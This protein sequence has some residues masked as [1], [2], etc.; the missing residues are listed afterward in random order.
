MSISAAAFFLIPDC[1]R[2]QGMC[3]KA[4]EKDPWQLYYVPDHF[5]AKEMYDKS[6]KDYFFSLQYIPDW[7]VT[8]QQIRIWDDDGE[9]NNDDDD[10]DD[11]DDDRLIKWYDG[12]KKC[13][14]QNAQIEKELMR[15]AWHP[16]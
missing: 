6:V 4:V 7:F 15:I 13:K 5:K 3:I 11:D 1:F 2:T 8:Q 9:Y 14:S 12:Y 10:D 16:S